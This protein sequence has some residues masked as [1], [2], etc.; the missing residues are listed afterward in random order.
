MKLKIINE[1]GQDQTF[2]TDKKE[3][4]IGRSNLCDLIVKSEC[5][6]R[7]HIQIKIQNEKVFVI[8]LGSANGTYLDEK[9][10]PAN[11]DVEWRTFFPIR[12]GLYVHVHFIDEPKHLTMSG[13]TTTKLEIEKPKVNSRIPRVQKKYVS[14]KSQNDAPAEKK[15]I[16][17]MIAI[18][19]AVGIYHFLFS[20]KKG[21]SPETVTKNIQENIQETSKDFFLNFRSHLTEDKCKTRAEK[22]LCEL[23]NVKLS[24]TEGIILNPQ[25]FILILDFKQKIKN[26]ELSTNELSGAMKERIKFLMLKMAMDKN[27]WIDILDVNPKDI[28]ILDFDSEERNIKTILKIDPNAKKSLSDSDLSTIFDAYSKNNDKL[29][30]AMLESKTQWFYQ[31]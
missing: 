18:L 30:K 15:P 2:S 19:I 3:F 1:N 28:Y 20:S 21:D 9:K 29:Y 10:I 7:K 11:E 23:L 13:I 5:I 26:N 4:T 22:K 25:Y 8:D 24:R 31:E 17:I 14:T 27:N 12:M 6:S 16:Q